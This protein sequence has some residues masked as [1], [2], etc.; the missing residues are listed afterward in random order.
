MIT[1]LDTLSWGKELVTGNAEFVET[2]GNV[3]YIVS[4]VRNNG[5]G[6]GRGFGNSFASPYQFVILKSDPVPPAP[7][8]GATFNGA[9]PPNSNPVATYTFPQ[10]TVDFD[11]VATFD[12]S[13]GLLHILGSR[14]T[15]TGSSTSSNQTNDLIKF[16]YDTVGLTLSGPFV[17]GASVGN[18]V[19]GAYDIGILDTGN[20]LIA[21]A[22]TDPTVTS[23]PLQAT[24]NAVKAEADLVTLFINPMAV[25]FVP[26]QWILVDDLANATFLNGAVLRVVTVT[27]TYVTAVFQTANYGFNQGFGDNFGFSF[28]S[29]LGA[30]ADTGHA[31]AMGSSLFAVE[32]D[33]SNAPIA[34][35]ATI[36]A[37]S[38]SRSGDTYDG[39]SL[40][41]SGASA[42]LYYQSHPKLVTFKDQ[43][44]SINRVGLN[45]PASVGFGLSF[46]YSFGG[47]G[48]G[49]TPPTGFGYNFGFGFGVSQ[50]GTWDEIPT[51]LFT[52]PA[53]YSDNRLT[54][55][56]SADGSRYLSLT[57]WS[58][59]NHPEGIVG[60]VLMGV[61]HGGG[62]WFF[63]PTFG[64]TAGGSIIQSAVSVARDNS[65]TLTYLLDPFVPVTNP[66]TATVASYPLQVA[67]VDPVTLG[68][69]NVPG[70]YNTLNMTWL[71]G[72]K[73]LIDNL[74]HWS[75]VGESEVTSTASGELHTVSPQ[76]EAL[77]NNSSSYFEDAGVVYFPSLTPLT[78]VA[79]NPQP[80]QYTVDTSIGLYKFNPA[81]AG[82][83][84][85]ISYKYVSAIVP[86][87]A[88][89]YNV[90][91]VARIA[92][93]SAT[94]WRNGTFYATDVVSITSFSITSGVI[95]V[96]CANDFLSGQRIALYGFGNPVNQF[97][98]GIVL[99]V[100]TAT[101][102]QFT[103]S[104][105]YPNTPLGFGN[106]FGFDFG[107]RF[108]FAPDSGF[109]AALIPGL[110]SLSA[111]GSTDA[112]QDAMQFVWTEN[113]PNL[114]DIFLTTSGANA[115]VHVLGAAGPAQQEF[116]VGVAVIDL[117]PDLVTQRHPAMTL[118][119]VA[120]SGGVMT[121]TFT[122]P[123]GA[124]VPIAGQQIMLY[125]VVLGAPPL[126]SFTYQAAPPLIATITG[127]AIASNALTVTANNTFS[128]GDLV[129]LSGLTTAT[130]LN[131][132]NVIVATSSSS[133]FTATL[134]HADYA[135]APDTGSAQL[136]RP[137]QGASGFGKGLTPG[138][139]SGFGWLFG[140]YAPLSL[141]VTYVNALGET[142]GS[143]AKLFVDVPQND[144]LKVLS[145]VPAGGA[146]DATGY[147]VYV[148]APG[149]E[150]LQ[151]DSN[152]H[153]VPTPLGQDWVEPVTG[154]ANINVF[155]PVASGAIQ[156]F[157]N[158]QVFTITS[159]TPT[160]LSMAIPFGFG[161]NFGFD[162]G[163]SSFAQTAITGFAIS[164]FQFAR[165]AVTVPLNVPPVASFPPPQ[166]LP[167]NVLATTVARNT[168]ITITPNVND[169]LWSASA[170]YTV[171]E[172][173]TFNGLGY[174]ALL[175]STNRSPDISPTFW[176][177]VKFPIVYTGL[178]DP[179]DVPTFQWAQTGGTTVVLPRGTTSSSLTIDTNGVI[180][181]GETLSFSLTI[182]D[183]I[184]APFST[185]FS[186]AV[187]PYTF[188]SANRDTLQVSRSVYSINATV[189]SVKIDTTGVGTFTT[190]SNNFSSGQQVWFEGV[191]NATFLNGAVFTILPTGFGQGFGA[192][193]GAP[194]LSSTQFQV[195]NPALPVY[196]LASD[197]G[198]AYSALPISQR[199]ADSS[200]AYNAA[201][202]Y[203]AG[204]VVT[205]N[206]QAFIAIQTVPL[207]T[208]PPNA[209]F[210]LPYSPSWSPLDISIF[211]NNLT[212]IKRT[213][214]LDGSDRYI[215]ISP[216]S[217]LVYG[218]F[219]S[220]NPAAV[221]LRRIFLPNNNL[222]ILD[223]VHTEQDYTLV[224]DS[225]GNIYR[226]TGGPFINT[227]NPDTTIPLSNFTTLSFADA[228][229]ANDVRI[230]TTVNFGNQR[231]V[232][233]SGEQGALLLQMNTTTLQVTG[234]FEL[235]VASN[236]VYGANKVQF[237]RWVNMDSLTSGRILL[238][239]ILN[240]QAP[241]T[242]VQITH[243]AVTVACNNTF[244]VGDMI[245]LSG[246]TNAAFLN[247]MTVKVIAASQT[248][249][250]FSLAHADY[251]SAPDT[252][253]AQSQTSGN[254][255]ETL[256]DLT[257]QQIIGTFDKS[258]LRNQFV[259]TGEIMF[260]P[261]DPYAGGPTPPV[262]QPITTTTFGG[263]TNIVLAWQMVRPDLISSYTVQVALTTQIAAQVPLVA[264]FTVQIPANAEFTGDVGVIDGT[265][266]AAMQAVS[267]NPL[268]MQYN[269]SST[270]LYTFSASQ[271]GHNVAITVRQA[272]NTFQVVNE[273][274]VQ[275][276][277]A[278][279]PAGST[280]FFRV[281]ASGLD[282]TSGFS[283]IQS[284]TL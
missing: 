214:V 230:L 78:E 32:L 120:I 219:Q 105:A 241:I 263:N 212:E 251:A 132:Q 280:Y 76:A 208:P 97:L 35:T 126:P 73:S 143:P 199:N 52:F 175:P 49:G 255:Y 257:N 63:H 89:L 233:V 15:P 24:I 80:G 103:A 271:A 249:F 284:V 3:L 153:F 47:F 123:Q 250:E 75:L 253:L 247:G 179:D 41:V 130:F 235:T 167:G 29:G 121:L 11:P 66:P 239:T 205:F 98:N 156:E 150:S 220:A 91:P 202:T 198:T 144:L 22:F 172:E 245:V 113:D 61:Q 107:T 26:N 106:N 178:T 116:E 118:Q 145:P 62:S 127:V 186:F 182:G 248:S 46:G 201:V 234:T 259:E 81:D 264:P 193:F 229:L 188:N 240:E 28:N 88:S 281:Q 114:T 129:S 77:V 5:F 48:Q 9:I 218:V 273:G 242:N 84:V 225:A 117:F 228:D 267:G 217:V 14:D 65:V 232:T 137:P 82:K 136:I 125:D 40:L 187:S 266:N 72:S 138:T 169:P 50:Y 42:D 25:P 142:V 56:Q 204:Q 6:F 163:T 159:A 154:F 57:Y 231:V 70:F 115:T 85:A 168:T 55:V 109:A 86:V 134:V 211:F 278:S 12:P 68:L 139:D 189:S 101:S 7:G 237:V 141:I 53:R 195:F 191:A 165:T 272:F 164:Q 122:A 203:S 200:P 269:A 277:L 94:T 1:V 223:A 38:P 119:D 124:I 19:R 238:G 261:D 131:G 111:A 69:T 43:V 160:T 177:A 79:T 258:K 180:L 10:P 151:P 210:W 268:T 39:V 246:L 244:A 4:N 185:V 18:R 99:T 215:V 192:G 196:P 104:V 17:V 37:S 2:S 206:G 148:G 158:N 13:T 276:I 135:S 51:V 282:G 146:G 161:I 100:S 44:F 236:F 149:Q 16:T 33:T 209:T 183:G 93:A 197:T 173:V 64:T 216:Y 108:S 140:E 112:D 102:T 23:P 21:A 260:D 270:G 279:F 157:L 174:I 243:N 274:S 31:L 60:S 67:S 256:I 45:S 74:S 96:V 110:L 30:V 207:S 283:N 152:G 275:S 213:S 27:P 90:P 20:S 190:T 54:V 222:T 262:L 147:N 58:Q 162:F 252:G 59:L 166:W 176:R 133:Q 95:T 194:S 83:V 226:Y 128:S 181:N 184:N 265:V 8:V 170:A 92:P 71:R 155:P 254:T 34:A 87:Y 221:L 171:G 224:L 36:I 227:D